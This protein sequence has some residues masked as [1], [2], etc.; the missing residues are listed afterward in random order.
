MQRVRNVVFVSAAFMCK[1]LV[2]TLFDNVIKKLITYLED[3]CDV[4]GRWTG[5]LGFPS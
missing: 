1:C 3:R 4:V 2:A 5:F